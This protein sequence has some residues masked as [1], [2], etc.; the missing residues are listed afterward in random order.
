MRGCHL[1][2]HGRC[3]PRPPGEWGCV[4]VGSPSGSSPTSP[5]DPRSSAL[6]GF[7]DGDERAI[8]KNSLKNKTE[9]LQISLPKTARA[10]S[11]SCFQQL[12]SALDY[13]IPALNY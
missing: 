6:E 1:R 3:S 9:T 12:L 10:V 5:L 13:T 8:L 4:Q 11:T 7:A 2:G